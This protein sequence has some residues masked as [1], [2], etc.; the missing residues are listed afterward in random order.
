[1]NI[2]LIADDNKKNLMQNFCIAYRGSLT[3][4]DLYATASTGTVIE[5]VSNLKINKFLAG[6]LGGDEQ[7]ATQIE[8][9]NIDMVFYLRDASSHK[10][11]DE[12]VHEIIRLCDLHNIPIATNLA[13]AELLIKGLDRGDLEWRNYV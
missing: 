7:I 5:E 13:T 11:P 12:Y 2:A 4:H 1:M 9:N 3:K 6:F 8:Q 10:A